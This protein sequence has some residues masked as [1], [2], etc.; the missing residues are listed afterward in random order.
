MM[1]Q[2]SGTLD[3]LAEDPSVVPSTHMLTHNYLYLQFQ[4]IQH[5]LLTSLSTRH[6]H[7]AHIFR[8]IKIK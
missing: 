3:A 5:P 8:H 4:G 1:A 6:T 7:S 2:Q